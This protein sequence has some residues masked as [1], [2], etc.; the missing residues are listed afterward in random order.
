MGSLGLGGLCSCALAPPWGPAL[1]RC[2]T[3]SGGAPGPQGSGHS[4]QQAQGQAHPGVHSRTGDG[5]V[6]AHLRTGDGGLGAHSRTGGG[7]CSPEDRRWCVLTRG[8]EMMGG[9][10]QDPTACFTPTTS[11][12]PTPAPPAPALGALGGRPSAAHPA[13]PHVGSAMA[14]L[15]PAHVSCCE[16]TGLGR[17]VSTAW[18]GRLKGPGRP[19][20]HLSALPQPLGHGRPGEAGG[21]RGGEDWGRRASGCP[22]GSLPGGGTGAR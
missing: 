9:F 13:R 14:W 12:S 20:G 5:G 18:L 22:Q 17:P 6:G 8:Q 2:W 7:G 10:P 15:Q 1:D 19:R 4:L 3:R 16:R 21:N 11:L